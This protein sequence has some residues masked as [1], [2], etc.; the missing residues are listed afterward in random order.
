MKITKYLSLL[1]AV[2]LLVCAFAVSAS[3]VEN[4]DI[5]VSTTGVDTNAGTQ[6]APVASLNK[7]LELVA[8]GGTIR[9]MDSFTAPADFVWESHNK[10][11][12]ISGGKLDLSQAGETIHVDDADKLFVYQGDAVTYD[13]LTLVLADNAYYCANGN[14]L[15][16]NANVTV[17][18]ADI[19]L[20]GGG[21]NGNTVASTDVTLLGGSYLR[22]YGGGYRAAVS[23]DSNLYLGAI[24]PGYKVAHDGAKRAHGGGYYANIG[25]NINLTIAGAT[26][27]FIDGGSNAD[28]TISGDINVLMTGGNLYSLY[29][30]GYKN[31]IQGNIN[32]TMNGGT[33]AQVFGANR[34]ANYE[35]NVAVTLA[36]GTI[37][38]RFFGG[39]YNNYEILG[40]YTA[41][42]HVI[43]KINVCIYEGMNFAWNSSEND[44][45]LYAHSRYS[46]LFDEEISNI[47]F[48]G[49]AAQ[50]KHEKNLG[51][52]NSGMQMVMGFASAADA[53]STSDMKTQIANWNIVLGDAIGANFYVS[54][55][56][57]VAKVSTLNITVAGDAVSY[58][59]SKLTP[60]ADGLYLIPVKVAAAQMT[61]EITLQ[62]VSGG[63]VWEKAT[64]TVKEYAQTILEGDY[65][66]EAKALAKYMLN[67]GAA[68]QQY[69]KINT[70]KLANAGCELT[71]EVALPQQVAPMSVSGA[72]DNVYFHGASMVFDHQA[73]LRFYF[74]G[75]AKGIDFGGYEAVT[76]NDKFYVEVSG[77]D[78]QDLDQIITITATKGQE[79]LCVS[80]SPLNYI[81]RMS[82]KGSNQ[83]Q[84]LVKAM[85][86][87]HQA[88]DTYVT[89][90]GATV[91]LPTVSGGAISTEKNDYL[92]GQMVTITVIP[93]EGYNLTSL[94]VMN[95]EEV[96]DLGEIPF[97]GGTFTFAAETG[98]Y[99]VDAKFAEK[100]FQDAENWD[101]TSQYDGVVTLK[102]GENGRTL[103]TYAS[104]YRDVAVTVKD[105]QEGTFKAELHF[106]F[107]EGREFQIRLHN[108]GTNGQY[109]VQKMATTLSS[110]WKNLYTLSEAEAAALT[111]EGVRFRVVMAGTKALAYINGTQIGEVDL[112][113][114]ITATELA[115]IKMVM[116]GN[117]GVENIQIPFAL[118]G[119][120]QNTVH[121]DL[122]NQNNGSVVL[123]EG[124]EKG[125]TLKT[126]E[127]DYRDVALTVKHLA[128]DTFKAEY[129]FTFGEGKQFQIRLHNETDDGSYKVQKMA[130]DLFAGWKNLY[131]LNASEVAA[132]KSDG[133][134]FRVVIADTYAIAFINGK[135]V[136]V[137]DLAGGIT[138][139]MAQIA[140]VMYGN[141]G[142]QN[143]EI[144]FTLGQGVAA[145]TVELAETTNGTIKTSKTICVAGETVTIT[146]TPDDGYNLTGLT[147]NGEPVAVSGNKYSFVAEVGTYTVAA[148]FAEKIFKD[149]DKYELSGQYDGCISLK[150]GSNSEQTVTTQAAIYADVSV[151]VRDMQPEIKSGEKG[152]F[153]AQIRFLFAN[154]KEYH[155]RLHNDNKLD[156][157][158]L[159]SMGN[160]NCITGWKWIKNLSSAQ[161]AKLRSDEGVQF[162]VA[163]VGSYAKVFIDDK[164][165]GT[166]DLSAGNVS[167][168][169][170]AQIRFVLCG[171]NGMENIQIPFALK[172]EQPAHATIALADAT[173]GVVTVDHAVCLVGETI[174][175]TAKPEEG[176]NLKSLV[177]KCGDQVAKIATKLAGG[178]YSYVIPA[179]GAYTVEAQFAA[180]LFEL[181]GT[182]SNYTDDTWDF[183]K[184]YEGLLNLSR[185]GTYAGIKTKAN[186]YREVSVT[187]SDL[188]PSFNATTGKGNFKMQIYFTFASGK[189]FQIR[190]HNE[191]ADGSYT[192]QNMGKDIITKWTKVTTL[193]GDQV[194]KLQSEVG[195]NFRIKL[196]GTNAIVY[197]DDVQVGTLDLSAGITAEDTASITMIMYGNDGVKT[198]ELPFTLG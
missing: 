196:E 148:S 106:V 198:M 14:R 46:P 159:Q 151:T 78:P 101:L 6:D 63:Q 10:D 195:V 141:V 2:V 48:M 137:V 149:T 24:N 25:G 83:M 8:D 79:S 162:R 81:V 102:K 39:C 183:S 136:G 30:G 140:I 175:V 143:L 170:T 11:V 18:G 73:A 172:E 54:V 90:C 97:A 145:A 93:E 34:N 154:G 147:V 15:Q 114:Q 80:Y 92:P 1:F 47:Y 62:L 32:L 56:E 178:T 128:E 85:Y 95:G 121:Y 122:T 168:D 67:Y 69:F 76:V 71:E 197:L 171:N 98:N 157:Y 91:V 110:G 138:N 173:D 169:T 31:N 131:T 185:A 19:Q 58:D 29:G 45:G 53:I 74:Y 22:I 112:A 59:L 43:G 4:H 160:T 96:V 41:N 177:V 17:S 33:V 156:T 176:Y 84:A 127:S 57:M 13:D 40:G 119:I 153:Q 66:N 134:Q 111:N 155:V 167:A 20:Y 135:Q 108:E 55:P 158:E 124:Y 75:S 181:G 88:A 118:G 16:I 35:G 86:G 150:V 68:A 179:Q 21:A 113:E 27:D 99:T 194:A 191:N 144:P 161:V 109:R 184:Q 37:S 50:S 26:A 7:A 105:F 186:T 64:F 187:V 5:Y 70:N 120:F 52:Q 188:A 130:T 23:G 36:G 180:P 125:R 72:I 193:N 165:M 51:S 100:I 142:V 44:L 132:L 190:L 12:T 115:Q 65:S 192:V 126:N 174:T 28:C 94:T 152:N 116:Y 139:E 77:I 189:Q 117:N 107:G 166:V 89:N 38:R 123:L 164:L 103:R 104:K 133:V 3:A 42:N 87:Y 129:H 61:E 182:G 9:I 82:E 60:H 49:N 146:A 163:L